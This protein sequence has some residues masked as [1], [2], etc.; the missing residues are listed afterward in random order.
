MYAR[1]LLLD[2]ECCSSELYGGHDGHEAETGEHGRM[3][4]LSPRI[5]LCEREFGRTPV[6]NGV[7]RTECQQRR[8]HAVST[9][10][11]SRAGRTAVV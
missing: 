2:W 11:A 1:E 5:Q 3:R 10:F 9:G 8:M 4:S 6:P 7:A